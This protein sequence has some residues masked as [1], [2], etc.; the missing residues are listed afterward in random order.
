MKTLN[1]NTFISKETDIELNQYKILSGLK[2]YRTEFNHNRLYPALSD[3]VYLSSVLE[4]IFDKRDNIISPPAKEIK[5]PGKNIFVELID[6]T[7]EAKEYSYDLID[8]TLPIIKGII[9]EAYIIYNFVEDNMEIGEVG[10]MPVYK[11]EGYLF[12]P[13]NT[14]SIL[15]IHNFESSNNSSDSQ[16]FHSLKTKFV[17]TTK[18]LNFAG[19]E[20]FIKMDLIKKFNEKTNIAA[21]IIKT[22]L[23]FPFD[24]TIFPIAKRKLLDYLTS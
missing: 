2:D 6:Q 7:T 17:Q 1:L 9:D 22:D 23:D 13:D 24:E 10:I 16:P 20:D 21:Y 15:Q 5:N 4:E 19:Y 8:W 3:L 11:N 12:V 18:M 14:K